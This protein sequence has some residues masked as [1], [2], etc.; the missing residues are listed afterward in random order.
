MEDITNSLT[1]VLLAKTQT[2]APPW[3]PG[4]LKLSCIFHLCSCVLGV[5]RQQGRNVGREV[6]VGWA[7]SCEFHSLLRFD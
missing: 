4:R 3:V 6:S 5:L 1:L 7:T 2:F